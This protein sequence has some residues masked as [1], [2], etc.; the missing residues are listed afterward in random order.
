M[1]APTTRVL[2]RMLPTAVETIVESYHG[3]I[4]FV[5]SIWSILFKDSEKSVKFVRSVYSLKFL[6]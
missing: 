2:L 5:R 3:V 4:R 6:R 1:A